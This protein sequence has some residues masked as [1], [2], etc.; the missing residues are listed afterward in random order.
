M[1]LAEACIIQISLTLGISN[2]GLS[3][4]FPCDAEF[5][6]NKCLHAFTECVLFINFNLSFLYVA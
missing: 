2:T 1:H 3:H 4:V 5:I 6:Y